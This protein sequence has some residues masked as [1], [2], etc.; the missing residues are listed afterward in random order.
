M[1]QHNS[2]I[3]VAHFRAKCNISVI[4]TYAPTEQASDE[5]KDAYYETLQ[6]VISSIPRRN[7]KLCVG[8]LNA[9]V[10]SKNAGN[11]R[12]MGRHGL[13]E[14]PNDNGWRFISFCTANNLV[15][16]GTLFQH[17]VSHK[18]TWTSPNGKYRNQID[19]ITISG[20]RR[21]SLLDTRNYKGADV[22]SD[23]HLLIATV[24]LKL[25]AHIKKD[26][27]PP[28][29]Q[30]EKLRD[31]P[32]CEVF[33]QEC[34][35]RFMALQVLDEDDT[36]NDMWKDIKDTFHNVSKEVLGNRKWKKRKK[37]ISDKTWKAIE[38]RDKQKLVKE[39]AEQDEGKS[40]FSKYLQRVNY[41]ILNKDVKRLCKEDKEKDLETQL[42]EVE[43]QLNQYGSEGVRAA[44]K[45]IKEIS[46]TA[47]KKVEMPVNNIQGQLITSGEGIKD[48]WQEHFRMVMNKTFD[49]NDRVN[50]PETEESIEVP[51]DEIRQEEI[52]RAIK[53]LKNGKAPGFDGIGAEMLK[54]G[55]GT[56]EI[57]HKL[58][59]KIWNNEVMPEDWK[60]GIIIKIPKKGDLR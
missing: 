23:H 25:K 9:K 31:N 19:H 18:Y 56:S 52:E 17:K 5:E 22:G 41:N 35:N 40:A 55:G 57:L 4:S 36:V 42:A 59:K 39:R 46:G 53:K 49:E 29:Y 50:I 33:A 20:E 14:E 32:V 6:D 8:D 44:H 38:K 47:R 58:F 15:I 10:G 11:E 16:G 37:W 51:I 1:L 48:R 45:M 28:K 30:L 3:L 27:G 24:K 26:Q 7:I 60:T 54:E 43:N 12:I 13:G 21:N 2:R 34:R